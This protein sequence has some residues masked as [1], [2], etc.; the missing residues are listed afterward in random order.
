MTGSGAIRIGDV[1]RDRALSALGDHF[2]LGRLTRSE[3]DERADLAL[4][5]RFR[6]DLAPLFVD[7]PGSAGSPALVTRPPRVAPAPPPPAPRPPVALMLLP[8]MV[9]GCV[10]VAVLAG[11]PWLLFGLFWLLMIKGSR[12]DHRRHHA[13]RRTVLSPAPRAVARHSCRGRDWRR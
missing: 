9:I 4:Q 3:Y 10:V 6:H 7:L 13:V 2:A 11:A 12:F 8:M 1:E 5:A